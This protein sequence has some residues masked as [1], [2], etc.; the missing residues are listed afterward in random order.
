MSRLKKKYREEVKAGLQTKF[1]FPNPMLVP[2]LKKIVVHMG[3]AAVTKEKNAIQDHTNELMLITGQKPI[4]TKAKKAISNFK[5]RIGQPLGLKVT[6]RGDRMYDFAD[7]LFN[8]V[9]PRIRDFHGFSKKG[10]GGGNYTLGIDDQQVFPELNLD[11]VKRTQGMHITFV[12]TAC[13]DAE[14]LELLG[15]LGLPFKKEGL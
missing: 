14:C 15:G 6:L 1:G 8:I 11:A 3:I 13:N 12:T 10:D 4:V 9:S 2:E 7:R 5:V